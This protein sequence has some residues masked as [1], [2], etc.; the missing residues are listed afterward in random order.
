MSTITWAIDPSHS[1]IGFKVKH[2]MFTNIS[3]KFQKFSS[4]IHT[5]AKDFE[6]AKIGFN[7]D[8]DSIT[9]GNS[10]RDG[11]LLSGDFFDVQQYPKIKFESISFTKINE[12]EYRLLG[13]LE[14]HGVTKEVMLAVEYGGQ[15]KD[16]WG[17]KKAG[18]I[19]TGKI[20]RKDFGLNWNSTL[21]TGGV[22]VGED[23]KL[24]IEIQY[25]RQ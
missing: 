1:E 14:L 20:N 13:N 3:G 16:P 9:T 25:V 17:N 19:I 11:H 18:F 4:I 2:M 21:D 15:N 5:D 10:E 6:N 8:V 22:L 12:S 7:A 23:V 24:E